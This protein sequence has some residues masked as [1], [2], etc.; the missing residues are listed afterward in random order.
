MAAIFDAMGNVIGDDGLT[1]W[2]SP[3]IDP[4]V[5]INNAPTVK[6]SDVGYLQ[7]KISEFQSVLYAVDTGATQLEERLVY[8]LTE[9]QVTDVQALL[10]Q[11]YDRKG[12]FKFAA[13]A[14]NMVSGTVNSF[15][16]SMQGI[17]LPSGLGFAPFVIPVG[18]AAAIAGAAVLVSFSLGWLATSSETAASIARGI[19]DPQAR[20]AAL[21]KASEIKA[22]SDSASGGTLGT[23]AS[24]A[25]YVAIA[26]ALYYAYKV[27]SDSK[28]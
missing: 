7:N 3:A 16:G 20:D 25:K 4:N 2:E 18:V 27:Y 15:G 28:D 9:Q 22:A 21:V 13:E 10:T 19:S 24:I 1:N 11:Y 17:Q 6:S 8:D 12:A 23:V 5:G 26:A 14:F